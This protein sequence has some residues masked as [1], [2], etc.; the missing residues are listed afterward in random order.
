MGC[1]HIH[2]YEPGYSEGNLPYENYFDNKGPV[3]YFLYAIP[4]YFQNLVVIKIFNDLVLFFL[5]IQM[6]QISK[7]ATKESS[8]FLNILSVN[9][10]LLYMSHPQGHPG[11]SEI[12]SLI[13]VSL[14]IK[15]LFQL[16]AIK[17]ITLVDSIFLFPILTPSVILLILSFTSLLLVKIKKLK[18]YELL[19]YFL[20]GG[21]S[22]FVFI[23]I[24]YIVKN[25]FNKLFFTLFLFPLHYSSNFSL[26]N[27]LKLS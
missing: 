18:N 7:L 26:L 17:P 12:Y 5:S 9:F 14:S 22:P 1:K 27:N 3:L 23:S 24:L 13:F 6:F 8:V 19:K 25:E 15:K 11:M 16:Q 4:T 20:Y 2:S 21:L 10:F